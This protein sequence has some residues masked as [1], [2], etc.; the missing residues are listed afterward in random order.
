MVNF[1]Y[2]NRRLNTVPIGK[3]WVPKNPD[4][5]KIDLSATEDLMVVA[6]TTQKE[7]EATQEA[8]EIVSSAAPEGNTATS[9]A[10]IKPEESVAAVTKRKRKSSDSKQSKKK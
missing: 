8:A 2:G 9:D 6:K 10:N 5:N 3:I 4:K 1:M 7:N